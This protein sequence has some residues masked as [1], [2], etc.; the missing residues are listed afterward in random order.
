MTKER[1]RANNPGLSRRNLLA[2]LPVSGLAAALPQVGLAQTPDPAVIAYD[3]WI[4]ARRECNRLAYTEA[5]ESMDTP[6]YI[7]ADKRERRAE[8]DLLEAVPTSLA[9]IGALA[10]FAWTEVRPQTTDPEQFEWLANDHRC[11]VVLAIWRTCT[12][13]EGYPDV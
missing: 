13:Q 4:E 11:Q 7:E 1:A 6:E 3:E 8:I 9:G 12:G 5:H 10:A 2:A